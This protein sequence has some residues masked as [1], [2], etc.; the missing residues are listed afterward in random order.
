MI[1]NDNI[2]TQWNINVYIRIYQTIISS[3][4]KEAYALI[5]VRYALCYDN[6]SF[7]HFDEL[8][9]TLSFMNFEYLLY[10]KVL[11]AITECFFYFHTI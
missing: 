6:E 10:I 9:K 4:I 7:G 5:F 2:Q 3:C 11:H 8:E 1:V